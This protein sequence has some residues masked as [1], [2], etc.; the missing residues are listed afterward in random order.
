M[1]ESEGTSRKRLSPLG[2]D[3]GRINTGTVVVDGVFA[4]NGSGL[5]SEGGGE[6]LKS[7]EPESHSDDSE[8]RERGG[9]IGPDI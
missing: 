5:G 2:V 8:E 7:D 3:G 4:G 6:A 1:N 9:D